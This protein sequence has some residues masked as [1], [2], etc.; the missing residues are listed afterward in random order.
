M[1]IG[2]NMRLDISNMSKEELQ[3]IRLY[4][5]L[6]RRQYYSIRAVMAL[7]TPD[8]YGVPSPV[9]AATVA[10]RLE[11]AGAVFDEKITALAEKHRIKPKRYPHDEL[12]FLNELADIFALSFFKVIAVQG[13]DQPQITLVKDGWCSGSP[14]DWGQQIDLGAAAHEDWQAVIISKIADFF[15]S[16]LSG[17]KP[18]P[19][20]KYPEPEYDPDEEE[21]PDDDDWDDAY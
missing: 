13:D 6:L 21:Y 4:C 10:R 18:A 19:K 20:Q 16:M 12:R 15:S 11:I 1:K 9:V 7:M 8:N 17:K 14:T 3:F 2:E 5:A